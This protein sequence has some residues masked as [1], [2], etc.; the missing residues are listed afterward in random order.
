MGLFMVVE[1]EGDKAALPALVAKVSQ[2]EGIVLPY[3]PGAGVS[4]RQLH[5]ATA[6]GQ[7]EIEKVCELYRSRS[8]V[9]A[10]LL[11]QDSDDTCPRDLAPEIAAWVRPLSL[12]FPVALVLFY[13]EYETLF[14]A[15][16]ASLQGKPL[17][18]SGD[19]P[20][21]PPGAVF[22]GDPEARRGAKGWVSERL[23]RRYVE[24]I[25]QLAFTRTLELGDQALQNL[26]SFR[27]L[28]S[29]LAFLGRHA[30]SGQRGKVYP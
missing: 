27:R 14:L 22:H 29:G 9:D 24:T 6:R 15:G 2:A 4:V 13:R 5:M 16:S 1:G 20:G 25:D 26:S 7:E 19:R 11:T 17:R 3:V 30:G 21:L 23:G 12:D 10:L 28:R 8:G 18:G